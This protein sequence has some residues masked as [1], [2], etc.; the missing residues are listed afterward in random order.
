MCQRTTRYSG[1][2][3]DANSTNANASSSTE[4]DKHPAYRSVILFGLA[5][6]FFALT[7]LILITPI[8]SGLQEKELGPSNDDDSTSTSFIY[9]ISHTFADLALLSTLSIL[10]SLLSLYKSYQSSTLHL[11]KTN[12]Y[13]HIKPTH[14]N[15]TPK[16]RE[17]KE[18]ESL[19]EPIGPKIAR[20]SRRWSSPVEILCLIQGLVIVVKCLTRLNVEIAILSEVNPHHVLFWLVLLVSGIQCVVISGWVDQVAIQ[21]SAIGEYRR[22]QQRRQN[23]RVN[24]TN[25]SE[26][27]L[28][29]RT[30][31]ELCDEE[32]P[33]GSS[34]R[35]ET[36][37][38][39]LGGHN[40]AISDSTGDPHYKTGVRDLVLLCYPDLLYFIAGFVFLI[41]ASVSEVLVP[42]I[43]GNMIDTLATYTPND[44][45]H[46]NDIWNVPGFLDNMKCLC[47]V[48]VLSGIFSGCRG[49]IFS[50]LGAR[51][52]VRL[53]SMLMD[54]LLSQDIGF[55]DTTKTGDITSRLSSDT[56]IVGD[57]VSY[58]VLIF[59]NSLVQAIGVLIFMSL[60]SWQ[61]TLLAF[62]SVPVISILSRFYGEFLRSIYKLMQKKLADGNSISTAA[63]GS[64]KTVKA[65]GAEHIEMKDFSLYMDQYLNLNLRVAVGILGY[66]TFAQGLPTLVTAV[67]LFYGGLLVMTDGE[68]HI[69]SGQLMA[70]LLYLTRLSNAFNGIG[71][72]MATLSQAV[73]AADKVFEWI[74]RKPKRTEART[75]A[76]AHN[77][78][79]ST[80]I[81]KFRFS[82]DR[83]AECRGEVNFDRV[84]MHYPSRPQRRILNEMNLRVPSGAIAALVGPSGG[85]KSSIISLVQN[86]YETSGG[87]RVL[88]LWM[89]HNCRIFLPNG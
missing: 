28:E 34:T 11:F 8:I 22:T 66:D 37:D 13:P 84:T 44:D 18:E 38:S 17:E 25:L 58:N 75:P 7:T 49:G 81:H 27:L 6:S 33:S 54:S 9:P 24:M 23:V 46:D 35:S 67:V 73:G 88:S 89:E 74:H 1:D 16:T 31:S 70:F 2:G 36:E 51:V 48:S 30:S 78:N 29:G 83:P 50:I 59:F 80:K 5:L 3:N 79:T 87:T 64:M 4:E 62:I 61:L 82:G 43:M 26:P 42:K 41:L 32:E 63:L 12:P 77:N 85:G 19:E 47:I 20:W 65:L 55:F 14:A 72:I 52:N 69:T 56:T 76:P 57:Q 10:L 71:Y 53:R 21:M 45:G 68:D 15:G 60:L 39:T 86:L 40:P